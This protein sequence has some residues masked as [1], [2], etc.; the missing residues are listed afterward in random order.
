MWLVRH[1]FH[2][3]SI[4]DSRE[5]FVT[6]HARG[7]SISAVYVMEIG[8]GTTSARPDRISG[9]PTHKVGKRLHPCFSDFR[10]ATRSDSRLTKTSKIT[11][12]FTHGNCLQLTLQYP[13]RKIAFKKDH[14][15][16]LPQVCRLLSVRALQLLVRNIH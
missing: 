7:V 11:L 4:T 5:G 13:S 9:S 10:P 15:R 1:R 6:L 2:T 14:T 8:S 16:H 12:S 3:T